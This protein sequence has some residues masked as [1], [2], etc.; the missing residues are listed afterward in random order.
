MVDASGGSDG[1]AFLAPKLRIWRR[2]ALYALL[3]IVAI[4]GL[5]AY[6][7]PLV[8]ARAAGGITP[9]LW[10]YLGIYIAFVALALAPAL[11]ESTRALGL[12][13][14]GYANA[15]VSM[16]RLGLAGSGRLYLLTM[17]VVAALLLGTRAGYAAAGVSLLI[18]AVFTVL[19]GNGLLEDL[20]TQP[21]NPTALRDWLEAG[22]AFLVFLLVLAVLVERFADLLVRAVASQQRTSNE[23]AS[24]A[25]TLK[26]RE[27]VL[28]RQKD[29]LE[30]LHDTAVGVAS[31]RDVQALLSAIVDRSIALVGAA[32]GW[33]YLVDSEHNELVAQVGT[34]MFQRHVGV[35]LKSGEGLSGRIWAEAR[36]LAIDSYQFWKGRTPLFEGDP[37]GPAMGVPL[38]V[39]G[40]VAGVIGLTRL[41]YSRPF[42]EE[43]LNTIGRLAEL[44]GIL[45]TNARLH[46]SLEQELA[47]RV[48]AQGALQAAYEDLERRVQERTAE[49]AALHA[50]ERERRAEAER[51]RRIADG[52]REIV[53]ALN[54][55]NKLGD[56]LDFIVTHAC[57]MLKSDGAAIFRLEQLP[58]GEQVLCVQA[59]CGLEPAIRGDGCAPV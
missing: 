11:E 33:L 31:A 25:R 58:A 29:M 54:Q 42:I 22:F 8:N 52:M 56:T 43:E 26:D 10:A 32:Y 53:A 14:L 38:F 23:L 4:A 24:T 15:I 1:P 16:M 28:V 27:E 34:G 18:Y 2:R 35:R 51:S 6:I 17:P 7:T 55:R 41:K 36:P 45:L 49:L 50:A 5:P 30:A 13:G 39:D 47:A 9:L 21:L 59:G 40:Q 12:L 3:T 57:R 48:E 19:A 37:I 46:G 20:I 44:A